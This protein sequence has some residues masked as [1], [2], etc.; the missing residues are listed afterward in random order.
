M[1]LIKLINTN[2]KLKPFKQPDIQFVTDVH[3][4]MTK[5]TKIIS[6]DVNNTVS[7]IAGLLS[8]HKVTIYC[9]LFVVKISRFSWITL[10]PQKLFGEFFHVNTKKA[11]K[12]W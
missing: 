4:V 2:S 8:E 5:N 6:K 1:L 7:V 10:Q 3:V 12:S 9:L 11:Y